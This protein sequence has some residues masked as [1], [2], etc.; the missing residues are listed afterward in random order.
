SIGPSKV[1]CEI[2]ALKA[3]SA[4]KAPT[5]LAVSVTNGAIKVPE[6]SKVGNKTVP[7]TIIRII[8]LQVTT[9]KTGVS[10]MAIIQ[11]IDN[12]PL[13]G[14][15]RASIN[16]IGANTLATAQISA[17][18]AIKGQSNPMLKVR[19][20]NFLLVKSVTP[21]DKGSTEAINH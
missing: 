9:T 15:T 21:C 18:P 2:E 3:T 17:R 13:F 8:L 14:K 19:S 10:P 20:E 16:M 11:Q 1:E 12:K 4:G 6:Y 7:I 5:C